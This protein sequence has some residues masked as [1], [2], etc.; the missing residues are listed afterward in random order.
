MARMR[1]QLAT[2]RRAY[3]FAFSAVCHG[4]VLILLI[5]RHGVLSPP[6]AET[7]ASLEKKF[8]IIWYPR[9][10][11]P[12]ISPTPK[13]EA[14]SIPRALPD[15]QRTILST[16]PDARPGQQLIWQPP[17]VKLNH[18]VPAPNIVQFTAPAL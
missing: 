1:V 17:V 14:N 7:R 10:K 9:P 6:P 18:E 16:R 12:D 15:A 13:L 11:L 2:R 3:S 8:A 4:L 5:T